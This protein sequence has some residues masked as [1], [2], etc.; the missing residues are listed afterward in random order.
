MTRTA[1]F[2]SKL[3]E[4]DV[5]T[6]RLNVLSSERME[7]ELPDFPRGT[8]VKM[9]VAINGIEF[10]A[11][12][13][14]LV[15]F[16]S[17]RITELVPAWISANTKI[18]LKLRGIN[19][20]TQN[21]LYTAVQV[22]FVRGSTKTVVQ[23]SC[24]DGEVLCAIPKELLLLQSSSAPGQQNASPERKP[25]S[26]SK[27]EYYA[28]PLILTPPILVDVWLGGVH[29]TVQ[30]CLSRCSTS[31]LWDVHTH[32]LSLQFTGMPMTLHVYGEIPVMHSVTPMNGPIYGGFT[33][34]IDGKGFINTGT[35]TVR[36]E[37]LQE[38]ISTE[39]NNSNEQ[40]TTITS[41]GGSQTRTQDLKQTPIVSLP[42]PV[43]PV[44]VN[45]KADFVSS[46]RL[47]C[48][49]PA[50]PQEGVYM[51]SV[52]LNGLE[53][54]KINATTWFLVWQNWQRRK[55]LLSSHGL[56]SH[57]MGGGREGA[58][59]ALQGANAASP[60]LVEDEIHILRRKGSF[61]LSHQSD[62]EGEG[63]DSRAFGGI[64]LPLIHKQPESSS[65]MRTVMEYYRE[66][67]DDE[68]GELVDPKLL[69]WHP[70]SAA[71][72]KYGDVADMQ[73]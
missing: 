15:V 4:S 39:I 11:C 7:C 58:M 66:L 40:Q 18:G 19:F 24:V 63:G 12:P 71:D 33:I 3:D 45:T 5:R 1:R 51:V 32:P 42:T 56:F 17:P 50:F 53:F 26:Q 27:N 43:L 10:F 22:S 13:G 9:F 65:V 47:L 20:T 59:R 68:A 67:L 61:M 8:I 28:D 73:S 36:F 72:E 6:S 23:G 41:T 49:P 52:S 30:T 2:C 35:I 38:Q 60:L 70:A 64:R 14:E 57:P 55:L 44:F 46:E 31:L 25:Q 29:K 48:A 21:P 37:L 69:H 54:S 16:Q 62:A 34:D